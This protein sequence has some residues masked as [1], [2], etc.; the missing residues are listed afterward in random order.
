MKKNL[1]SA[2]LPNRESQPDS[3]KKSIRNLCILLGMPNDFSEMS[4][5]RFCYRDVLNK[6]FLC[7]IYCKQINVNVMITETQQ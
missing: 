2:N 3:K 1:Y 4:V 7:F 6:Q 5:E